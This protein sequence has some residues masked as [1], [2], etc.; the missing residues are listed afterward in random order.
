VDLN[1]T[2]GDEIGKQR[3]ALVVSSDALGR[4][5]LHIIVPITEW[6][7][8]F[9]AYPWFEKLSPTAKNGLS[10]ESG[11][12]AFQLRSV[13]RDRFQKRLG[14]VPIPQL[15]SVCLKIGLCV[16]IDLSDVTA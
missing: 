7:P 6:K 3:T 5:A 10:K 15:E 8:A 1:P 14:V 16:G 4:L 12:D 2:Q 13:S 9:A 11:A